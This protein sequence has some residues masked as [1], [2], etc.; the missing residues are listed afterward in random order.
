MGIVAYYFMFRRKQNAPEI[1]TYLS[2]DIVAYDHL[3]DRP[4]AVIRDVTP[5]G[6]LA[7]RMVERFNRLDLPLIHLKDAVLDMLE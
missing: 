1:G 7:Y 4:A 6:D 5:D 2:Y 3:I